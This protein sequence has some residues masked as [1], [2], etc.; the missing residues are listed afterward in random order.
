MLSLFT[1]SLRNH[2]LLFG[3][4][5]LLLISLVNSYDLLYFT[6]V[7]IGGLIVLNFL[8]VTGELGNLPVY[9][10]LSLSLSSFFFAGLV[11]DYMYLLVIVF[12][13]LFV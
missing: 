13:L 1:L 10:I 6:F 5:F 12:L 4:V 7:Y 2:V 9:V 8:M 11:V 3:V